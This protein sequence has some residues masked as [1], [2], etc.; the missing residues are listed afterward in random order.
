MQ[1]RYIK[2]NTNKTS[3]VFFSNPDRTKAWEKDIAKAKKPEQ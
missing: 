1:V 3:Y 2:P